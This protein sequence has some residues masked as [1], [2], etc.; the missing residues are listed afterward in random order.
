MDILT[1]AIIISIGLPLAIAMSIGVAI[2]VINAINYAYSNSRARAMSAK[3]LSVNKINSYAN[4]GLNEIITNLEAEEYKD[5]ILMLEEDYSIE[6]LEYAL[7]RKSYKLDQKI[8]S[9]IP[10]A[11]KP[12]FKQLL[13]K[14]DYQ[15]IRVLV[16]LKKANKFGIKYKK[17]LVPTDVFNRKQFE[18][19]LNC[20]LEELK[21]KLRFTP[22]KDLIDKHFIL[23]ENFTIFDFGKAMKQEYYVRLVAAARSS[24][25][26]FLMKYVKM[27]IDYEGIRALTSLTQKNIENDNIIQGG[28]L[29]NK[30][31]L[32]IKSAKPEAISGLISKEI[33][34]EYVKSNN[35]QVK[36]LVD[37]RMA[38]EKYTSSLANELFLNNPMSINSVL[39]FYIKKEIEILNLSRILKLKSEG[40]SSEIIR[41]MII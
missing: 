35:I 8:Y 9:I 6:N 33:I 36:S 12:F 17:L 2:T 19:L 20:T 10:K 1:I 27:T 5:I 7:S 4:Q 14:F 40:I 26:K 16:R 15:N 29:N 18:D 22:Y 13:A 34:G 25:S 32:A 41:E 3:L 38:Y 30:K 37:L 23:N 39:G 11:E 24:K 31:L 28:Y 21:V